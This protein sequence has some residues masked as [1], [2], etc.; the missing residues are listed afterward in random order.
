MVG[1]VTAVRLLLGASYSGQDYM[2]LPWKWCWWG[3]VHGEARKP[4]EPLDS[5]CGQS[6]LLPCVHLEKWAVFW[7]ILLGNKLC[8]S[9]RNWEL[10]EEGAD[11][12]RDNSHWALLF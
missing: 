2:T 10:R 8:R 5:V 3:G 4:S 9:P 11:L 7:T 1:V 12:V 6:L